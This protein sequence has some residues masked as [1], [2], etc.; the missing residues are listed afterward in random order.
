MLSS[1]LGPITKAESADIMAVSPMAGKYDEKLDRK[2][3][4]KLYP[5]GQKRQRMKLDKQRQMPRKKNI[6]QSES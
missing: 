2:S 5:N 4:F 3:A 6:Q 1:Q